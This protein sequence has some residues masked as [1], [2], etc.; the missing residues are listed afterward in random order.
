MGKIVHSHGL[1]IE[2]FYHGNLNRFSPCPPCS[3]WLRFFSTRKIISSFIVVLT[4]SGSVQAANAPPAFSQVQAAHRPSDGVLRDRHGEPLATVRLDTNARRLPWVPLSDI[5]PALIEAVTAAEDKRFFAHSGVD[6]VG[7]AG[8]AWDNALGR[9]ERGASSISMQV[10]ALLD[11]GLARQPG[12]RSMGKKWTQMQAARALEQQW[13]KQQ[14]LETYLNRITYRGELQGIGAAS[15]GLF[16]KHPS[17]L[18][19]SEASLLAA[20][21]RAPG[22]PIKQVAL[23]AC[24]IARA[25]QAAGDCDKLT[26]HAKIALGAKPNPQPVNA[27][28]PHLA[29][30]LVTTET[31]DVM[32]SLDAHTQRL[33]VESLDHHLASLV[34]SGVQDGAVVVLDNVSGEVLAYVGASERFSISPQVDGVVAPRQ[35]GSTLK[36]LLYS[37]ALEKRLLT[38]ATLLDDTPYNL[39]TTNGLYVPQNYE[40]DYKGPVSVRTA[41]GASLNIPAVRTIVLTGVPAFHERMKQLGFSTLVDDPEHYGFSLALGASDVKL[42]DLANAY[43]ALANQGRMSDIR[44]TPGGTQ[45]A[46]AVID[47]AAAFIVTD[48]MSDR[49]A[50]YVTFGFD[51]PLATRSWSAVKTGTSKDM[52]DNWAVGFSDR[53]TVGVWVGNFAGNPMHDVSGVTGAA[54]IWADIM[55]QLHAEQSSQAPHPPKGVVR[56]PVRFQEGI[57]IARQDWFIP[58]TEPDKII[59]WRSPAQ[60]AMRITYPTDGTIIALDPAIPDAH[61]GIPL[62]AEGAPGSYNWQLDGKP[63]ERWSR[64]NTAW[65]SP[66]PGR[67]QLALMDE[68]GKIVDQIR[69]EVRGYG[70]LVSVR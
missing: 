21:I 63:L 8:A 50:R 22:A 6:W 38:A 48:I 33:A 68:S 44:L 39:A 56:R 27:L 70:E 9:S 5:S 26:H 1:F 23:R 11:A 62:R 42:L 36:P 52:R 30:R 25:I 57:E 59:A 24:A 61:Q 34:A 67:H 66:A 58:G 16:D 32:S 7:V 60:T 64:G 18:D 14:I 53:Y 10:A 45:P 54:P 15:W 47:P 4:L 2:N 37:L 65:L 19:R 41:L 69:F 40:R 20:L 29:R 55:N 51:N 12:G 35:A 3:P 43:R 13:S 46:R 17:G 31:R 49:G 28:A